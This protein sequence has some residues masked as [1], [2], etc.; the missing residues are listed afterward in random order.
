MPQRQNLHTLEAMAL[1]ARA[2]VARS[3]AVF[4][5]AVTPL[6]ARIE[7]SCL[8]HG[9]HYPWWIPTYSSVGT[10]ALAVAAVYQR[11]ALLPPTPIALA[12]LLAISPHLIWALTGRILP[13]LV[14]AAALWAAVAVLLLAHPVGADLAPFLLVLSAA[15]TAATT[16]VRNA[17]IVGVA[18]IG[19]LAGIG[20]AAGPLDNLAIYIV[21]VVLGIDVG[22]ALRWQMRAL[23]AERGKRAVERDQAVLAERQRIAREVHDVV[24]HSLSVTMLHVTGARHTLQ[25]DA[26]VAD[27]IDA[28]T[29]AE[30]VGRE[31]MAD[32][33]RA[34]GLFAAT[35]QPVRPMPCAADIRALVESTRAAGLAV[36]YAERGEP[37][38]VPAATGLGLYRIAQESLANVAKHAPGATASVQLDVVA[39]EARL[40]IRNDLPGRPPR[41]T[42][43]GAGLPGMAA[44]A[45]QLGGTLRAG[46]D[47][48][49]WLV[50]VAVSTAAIPMA[51]KGVG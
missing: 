40:T 20:A 44:R 9:L 19:L 36:D 43:D 27:A 24:G 6:R 1:D 45:A 23:T 4:D 2:L 30:R 17:G 39:D 16:S 28:L 35:S 8:R 18:G 11:G 7:A 12:G 46:P 25:R 21:G 33:R 22:V 29:E 10:V 41:P 50:H 5:R 34:V 49:G 15:E 32:I 31:A 51:T 13:A 37:A 14:E 26:D 47:G 48:A 42:G 3:W 38:V